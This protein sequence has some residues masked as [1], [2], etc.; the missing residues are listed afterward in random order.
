[1]YIK[2][3]ITVISKT[4]GFISTIS[5]TRLFVFFVW[6]RAPKTA[7][8]MRQHRRHFGGHGR[9]RAAVT[10]VSH[11]CGGVLLGL[12]C[13]APQSSTSF[14]GRPSSRGPPPPGRF[15]RFLMENRFG[16]PWWWMEALAYTIA[17][18]S[19]WTLTIPTL[20][21]IY[22]WTISITQST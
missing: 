6:P 21:W 5:E 22:T 16:Y 12:R 13:G 20:C 9:C 14:P 10:T 2:Y 18:I 3:F 19:G 7:Q 1:M 8:G 17:A 15:R 4:C 11:G